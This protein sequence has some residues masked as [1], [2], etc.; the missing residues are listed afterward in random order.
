MPGKPPPCDAACPSAEA[1]RC[2][3]ESKTC[4][5]VRH[6]RVHCDRGRV[7]VGGD[8]SSYYVKQLAISAVR[9]VFPSAPVVLD[10]RV[11]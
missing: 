6:L 1:L 3:I 2:R 5:R 9:E 4:G 10:I 8:T 7:T 11:R